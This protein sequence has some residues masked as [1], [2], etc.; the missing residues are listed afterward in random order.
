MTWNEQLKRAYAICKKD[1]RIYYSK[2][3]VIIFGILIP[4]FLYL[5]FYIGRE[6]KPSFLIQ[7]M[8]GMSIFFTSTSVIPVIIP[9]E[10]R[11]RTLERLISAPVSISM[12]L[13]GDILASFL[14]GIVISTIPLI[15]GVV[16]GV[17]IAQPAIL[18]LGVFIAAFCFSSMAAIFSVIPT[19]VPANVMMLSNLIKFPLIFIS[20]VFTPLETMPLWGRV[21]SFFSPLTYFIDL[22]NISFNGEITASLYL[23]ML[24]LC[25]FALAFSITAIKMHEKTMFKRL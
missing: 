22:A 9:W 21:F 6:I 16:T 3:P 8:L 17:E 15:I 18:I 19:D 11:M 4:F 7:G 20:G 1:I 12:I 25:L 10:S 2:G 23:D 14:F 13:L 24:A 5:A